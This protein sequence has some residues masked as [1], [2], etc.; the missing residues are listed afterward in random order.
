MK[1]PRLTPD[2]ISY[3]YVMLDAHFQRIGYTDPIT[4][5]EIDMS[6][7]VPNINLRLAIEHFLDQ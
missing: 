3:D 2:G 7:V 5:K 6:K 1:D 4:R